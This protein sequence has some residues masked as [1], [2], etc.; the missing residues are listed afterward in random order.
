MSLAVPTSVGAYTHDIGPC[1]VSS[2][3]KC[4]DSSGGQV[5][6]PWLG[7]LAT[8]I[9]QTFVSEL[10]TKSITQAGN[11]RNGSRP[12]AFATS[13]SYPISHANCLLDRNPESLAYSYK[14]G[15]GAIFIG[16]RASTGQCY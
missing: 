4:F 1:A 11:V 6:N 15:G 12:C 16:G 7:L 5:Y 13:S 9:S 10:C 3:D 14:G 2:G 8:N